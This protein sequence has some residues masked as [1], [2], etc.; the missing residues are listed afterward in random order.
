MS[1]L[2]D[3]FTN[4]VLTQFTQCTMCGEE[5]SYHLDPNFSSWAYFEDIQIYCNNCF[6]QH[7][8]DGSRM[9]E[10]LGLTRDQMDRQFSELYHLFHNLSQQ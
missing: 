8:F 7:W 6:F 5:N 1:E 3:F 4:K 10:S 2:T 9:R